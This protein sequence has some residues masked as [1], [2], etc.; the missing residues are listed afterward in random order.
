MKLNATI[1]SILY[2]LLILSFL[3]ILWAYYPF[4]PS[5][6]KHINRNQNNI[7][8][9]GKLMLHKNGHY[10]DENGIVWIKRSFMASLLHRPW[11]Y[12]VFET[13]DETQ[14]SSSEVEVLREDFDKDIQKFQ[15]GSFNYYSS[16]QTPISHF[17]A[18]VLPILLYLAPKYTVYSS[19]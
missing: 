9:V 16:I 11:K 18:D 10:F 4:I 19:L 13:Y 1:P 12:Y 7:F 14:E 3:F 5:R 8:P 15:P 6:M 2:L 17:F